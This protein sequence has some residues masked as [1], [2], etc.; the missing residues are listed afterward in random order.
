[1]MATVIV[2]FIAVAVGLFLYLLSSSAGPLP[3]SATVSSDAYAAGSQL[4][5]SAGA[6]SSDAA[7]KDI[8]QADF[9]ALLAD[10]H[11]SAQGVEN[12][13]FMDIDS[14]GA[15]EALLLVRGDGE[16]RPLDLY[17]YKVKDG[18]A[19][20]IFRE[21]GVAQGEA[22]FQGPRLVVTEGVYAPG[23]PLCCPSS[24]KLTYYVFKD[25]ALVVSKV[26]AAPSGAR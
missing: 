18:R 9:A 5:D 15:Q 16:N 17:L 4:A 11:A 20:V 6:V 3:G 25:G 12:K 26:E 19:E 14:D 1:M 7:D 13:L 24:I 10:E 21:T 23:D 22:T 2:I 8:R